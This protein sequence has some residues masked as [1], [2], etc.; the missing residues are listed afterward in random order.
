[1]WND[2][3]QSAF[4]QIKQELSSTPV[5]ALYDATHNTIVSADASSY[6][7]GGVLM[8]KQADHQWKPVA[9]ASRSLTPTE[10]YAQIEK[11]AL[12]ITW[13]CKQF[14]EY[15]VGMHF[16]VDTDHKQ[17]VSLLDNK[18]L[19]ELPARIQRFKMLMQFAFSIYHTPC[20]TSLLLTHCLGHLHTL[21]LLQMS[22]FV[23]TQRCLW[24]L[25]QLTSLLRQNV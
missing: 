1:V 17:L 9:Y 8:Q 11:E 25:S 18:N 24:T 12:G 21:L 5:L 19:E 20:K 4:N 14:S 3:Q 2:S 15:L 16:K 23:K 22:N 7:L 13:A 10:K 6:G